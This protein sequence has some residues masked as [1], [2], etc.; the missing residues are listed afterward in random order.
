MQRLSL[1]F[2]SKLHLHDT[3]AQLRVHTAREHRVSHRVDSTCLSILARPFVWPIAPRVVYAA[4]RSP[5]VFAVSLFP[6]CM[7]RE[8]AASSRR[9]CSSPTRWCCS[10]RCA[11]ATRRCSS[12]P[13]SRTKAHTSALP[14]KLPS[15]TVQ[16]P[17]G[18]ASLPPTAVSA[19]NGRRLP[20]SYS[21][22]SA[23][24]MPTVACPLTVW[25]GT[26]CTYMCVCAA[27]HVLPL[28]GRGPHRLSHGP[29]DGVLRQRDRHD[30]LDGRR[31]RSRDGECD[32][33]LPRPSPRD[34]PALCASL[35][36]H[37]APARRSNSR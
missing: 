23:Q 21:L 36:K 2:D 20:P 8:Q 37:R 18:T 28:L 16:W 10:G 24:C 13:R 4:C 15:V 1:R 7:A 25:C 12:S 35:S 22:H 34:S 11:C 33:P 19:E 5:R 30:Q 29:R 26:V 32:A 27:G 17:M 9:A 3:L 6:A 14:H 31:D